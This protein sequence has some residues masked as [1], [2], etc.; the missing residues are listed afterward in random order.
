MSLTVLG[1]YY[2]SYIMPTY[3]FDI[4]LQW[5]K[6]VSSCHTQA[7]CLLHI[8]FHFVAGLIKAIKDTEVQQHRIQPLPSPSNF[9]P[10][11]QPLEQSSPSQNDIICQPQKVIK[12]QLLHS[13]GW[14]AEVKSMAM[15]SHFR[16]ATPA[17]NKMEHLHHPCCC[18]T[19]TT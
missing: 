2:R 5:C 18:T 11:I 4:I 15:T 1:D 10:Q 7:L 19:L 13:T 9:R 6:E 17:K 16:E 12:Q 14:K 8:H 3:W